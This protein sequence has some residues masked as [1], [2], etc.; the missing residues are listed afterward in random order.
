VDPVTILRE[1]RACRS[2]VDEITV[3]DRALSVNEVASI[4]ALVLLASAL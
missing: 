1:H 2:M 4:Y 3:Y